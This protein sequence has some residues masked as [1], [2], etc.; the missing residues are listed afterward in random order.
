MS[1]LSGEGRKVERTAAN[2]PAA[3]Q[4][5]VRIETRA[6]TVIARDLDGLDTPL[7]RGARWT[8]PCAAGNASKVTKTTRAGAISLHGLSLIHI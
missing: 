4:A 6:I 7:E 1:F 2:L 5:S 8:L 3:G